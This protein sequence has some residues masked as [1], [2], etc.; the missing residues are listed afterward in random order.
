MSR[1]SSP[2]VAKPAGD[3]PRRFSRVKKALAVGIAAGLAGSAI[4]AAPGVALAGGGSSGGNSKGG[5]L[6]VAFQNLY[7]GASLT[8]A[9]E[10]AESGDIVAFLTAAAGVY[11]T[12]QATDF[13][14][15]AKKIAKTMKKQ[16]P[17]I[18]ALNE[19]TYWRTARNTSGPELPE[20]NFLTILKKQLAKRGMNYKV[21]AKVKNADLE[22]PYLK[23]DLNCA[24]IAIPYSDSDCTVT[25][26][27]RDVILIKKKKGLSWNKPKSGNYAAQETFTVAG[28]VLSFDRGWAST[29]VKYNG[30]KMKVYTSHLEV[31]EQALGKPGRSKIQYDQATELLKI[32]K[33]HKNRTTILAGDLNTDANGQT[34]DTYAKLTKSFFEDSWSQAGR[35]GK[36]LTCCQNADLSNKKSELNQ[37]RIDLVLNHGKATSY[38][39]KRLGTEKFRK[40]PLP[41]WESDHAGYVTKMQVG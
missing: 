39:A 40:S 37:T 22:I 41:L 17:N 3:P 29:N 14:L 35:T 20:Y 5:D 4:V 1:H 15:R 16:N 25:L 9:I 26:Q 34:S 32:M 31:E 2:P 23:P 21:A 6:T 33:K 7:L 11:D 8:P 12:A 10:A 36:G 28:Q 38:W 27:D 30:A 13:P 19:V 24:A 18:L